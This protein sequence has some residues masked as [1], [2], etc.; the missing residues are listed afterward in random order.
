ML[1]GASSAAILSRHRRVGPYLLSSRHLNV[2]K[3]WGKCRIVSSVPLGRDSDSSRDVDVTRTSVGSPSGEGDPTSLMETTVMFDLD[4]Y[5]ATS[6]NL[7]SPVTD[8]T[9]GYPMDKE[10]EKHPDP[11]LSPTIATPLAPSSIYSSS[12]TSALP[13]WR[14]PHDSEIFKMVV[15]ALFAVLLD[16]V[17]N[18][19]D[20]ALVGRLGA[21]HLAGAG[22]AGL[23]FSFTSWIFGFLSLVCTPKV[24]L[25]WATGDVDTAAKHAG[26]SMSLGVLIGC[27]LGVLFWFGAEPICALL[28]KDAAVLHHATEYLKWRSWS[29]PA[30]LVQFVAF[31]S[32]RG[33]KDTRTPLFASFTSNITNFSLDMFLIF[34]LGWGVMGASLASSVAVYIG[35]AVALTL[36]AQRGL[37][38]KR[39]LLRVP[40]WTDVAPIL[41]AG[42]AL[43]LR[44]ISGMLMVLTCTSLVSR[45]GAAPLAAH[46]IVRQV[47]VFSIMAYEG[48]N[49]ASQALIA[50]N[51]G[52]Q[53]FEEARQVFL[54]LV[55]L[56]TIWGCVVA[57]IMWGLRYPIA[58]AFTQDTAVVGLILM[59]APV[60]SFTQP[61]DS[62]TTVLDGTLLGMQKHAFIGRSMAITT[63][64]SVSLLLFL[65][66]LYPSM[67]TVWVCLKMLTVGRCAA[68]SWKLTRSKNSPFIA[69][70]SPSPPTPSVA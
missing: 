47:W 38:Q 25:A 12:E 11:T 51:V 16:P 8:D 15:P 41:R 63:L 56:S 29:A 67:L 35:C 68:A 48:L 20:T 69:Q 53:K 24:A 1:C 44:T 18:L 17:M 27:V 4:P 54:R 30:L 61:L 66:P 34:G 2:Q 45:L 36:L 28:I 60:V 33:M 50:V 64:L 6:S 5:T 19:V 14:S 58:T 62:L 49:A 46:E 10:A 23:L 22:A 32:F 70:P 21:A 65:F 42:L 55:T 59:L 37:L 40:P 57:A 3:Y 52:Q 31:G 7:T 43:S 26:T 13:W 39:F 9:T